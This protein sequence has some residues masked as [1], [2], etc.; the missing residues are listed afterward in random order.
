V[1]GISNVPGNKISEKLGTPV[2]KATDI[3]LGW[4][5]AREN[6]LRYAN[7]TN[8]AYMCNKL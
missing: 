5:G 8:V 7:Y 1:D 2:R 6:V 3:A 4:R